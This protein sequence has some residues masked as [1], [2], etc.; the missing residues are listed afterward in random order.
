MIYPKYL[1]HFIKANLRQNGVTSASKKIAYNLV[2][3]LI[4]DISKKVNGGVPY[5]YNEKGILISDISYDLLT[6][7]EVIRLYDMLT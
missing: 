2:K 4:M 7:A 6:N 1:A 5:V 3:E